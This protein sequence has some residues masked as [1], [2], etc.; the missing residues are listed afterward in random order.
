ML[1]QEAFEEEAAGVEPDALPDAIG[2]STVCED[3]EEAACVES[4]AVGLVADDA[5]AVAGDRVA[6]ELLAVTK[7]RGRSTSS[8]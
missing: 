5:A 3:A 8:E 1:P 2:L 7:L 6:L 4:L